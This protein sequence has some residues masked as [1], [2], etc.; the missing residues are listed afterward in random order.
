MPFALNNPLWRYSIAVYADEP[1]QQR[2]LDLQERHHCNINCL[3][4]MG[5][6]AQQHWQLSPTQWQQLTHRLTPWRA[7]TETLRG[8]RVALKPAAQTCN[9]AQQLRQQVK[10]VELLSEQYQL[11]IMFQFG[12]TQAKTGAPSWQAMLATQA[13]AP[14]RS[15]LQRL[16]ER[17]S[18][19][20]EGG[21]KPVNRP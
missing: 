4:L 2:L 16:F 3:L 5:W 9:K 7:L 13:L 15:E 6:L 19:P 10:R 14:Y 8:Q 1:L 18:P 12:V 21:E 17:A 11:A 20:P